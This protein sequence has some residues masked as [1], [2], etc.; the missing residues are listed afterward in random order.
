MK[1][2]SLLGL[3]VLLALAVGIGSGSAAAAGGKKLVEGTVFDATCVTIC[4]PPPCGP[5]PMPAPKSRADVICAQ[6]QIVCPLQASPRIC[7]PSSN[8]GGFPVYTGEGS[9]VNVRKRGSATVLAR[10][11]IVEG[12]FKIELAPGEYVFHPYMAEEQCWSAEPVTAKIVRA[13]KSPVPVA[14]D[15]TNRCIADRGTN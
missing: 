15:A 5:V 10:L 1:R 12:H 4:C 9:L 11:P 6:A 2:S 7:L 3:V 14:L 13:L 8:C